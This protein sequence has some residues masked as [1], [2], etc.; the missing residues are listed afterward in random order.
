MAI[1][2]TFAGTVLHV[3]GLVFETLSR[4]WWRGRGRGEDGS[5]R[6]VTKRDDHLFQTGSTRVLIR[7]LMVGCAA[8]WA[9][10]G[11]L[12]AEYG[13]YKWRNVCDED[14]YNIGI[15]VLITVT[16]LSFLPILGGLI[17]TLYTNVYLT[18]RAHLWMFGEK[19]LAPW[20]FVSA[21]A[22]VSR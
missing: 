7:H 14:L 5:R 3:M 1:Y 21:Y 18:A 12:Y 2:L 17:F 13:V 19:S 6:K 8:A 9:I 16:V 20:M 22:S 10:Q 11:W 4:M 15:S